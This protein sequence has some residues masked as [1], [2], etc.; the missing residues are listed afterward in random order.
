MGGMRRSTVLVLLMAAA[1]LAA[2]ASASNDPLSPRQWGLQ[3]IAAPQAW[4]TAKGDGIVI[5]VSDTGVDVDHP[6]I[7]AKVIGGRDFVDGGR[8]DDGHGHGTHVAGVAAAITDNNRGVAGTAPASRV[9]AY[10]VFDSEGVYAGG[11]P[12]SI[13]MAADAG[14]RV[15]NLSWGPRL[16][17]GNLLEDPAV[18]AAVKYAFDRGSVVVIAAGNDGNPFSNPTTANYALV[19]GAT[20]RDDIKAAYSTAGPGVRIY[21]PGGSESSAALCE[22]DLDIWSTLP[23]SSDFDCQGNGYDTLSGTSFAAPHVAGVAALMLSKN[24]S[25]SPTRVMEIMLSTADTIAGGFKR[26]NAARAVAATPRPGG[27]ST[28]GGGAPPSGGGGGSTGGGG[29][30]SG[31]SGDG[32]AA[33]SSQASPSSEARENSDAS[34]APQAPGDPRSVAEP[35]DEG[36]FPLVLGG[37]L[38]LL[39]LGAGGGAYWYVFARKRG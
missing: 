20:T 14:A 31:S 33:P 29:A 7:G 25:I 38:V 12:Q 8:P 3:R 15:I 34:P 10:R 35:A 16:T 6:D 39:L 27:G 30:S 23:P 18:D 11:G 24:S 2:P 26:V 21:A 1:L 17:V 32:G 13:R 19:T 9:L 37:A 36:N 4:N 22:S 5:A 28:G